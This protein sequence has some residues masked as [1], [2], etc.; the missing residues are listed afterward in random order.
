M[1]LFSFL[2]NSKPP[3][4]FSVQNCTG[5]GS[6]E[7]Q[8]RNNKLRKQN[9]KNTKQRTLITG[10]NLVIA[11]VVLVVV[12]VSVVCV[13]ATSVSTTTSILAS[14]SPAVPSTTSVA[15]AA[16]APVR[17]HPERLAVAFPLLGPRHPLPDQNS[18]RY[19]HHRFS[20]IGSFV[21]GRVPALSRSSQKAA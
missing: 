18:R 12:A 17:L 3:F 14:A 4:R 21:F 5:S 10:T 20:H 19:F 11:T 13:H 16:S 15:A 8:E 2:L 1:S 6:A 9:I 7:A